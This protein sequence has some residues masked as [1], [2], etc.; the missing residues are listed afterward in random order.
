MKGKILVIEDDHDSAHILEMLFKAG[1][2][3]VMVTE[4]GEKGL[5]EANSLHPDLVVLDVMMPGLDGYDT[6]A[7]IKDQMNIPVLMLTAR[8]QPQDVVRGFSSGA[9]DYVKKPYNTNELLLR[10]KALV[11]RYHANNNI[12][13]S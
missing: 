8:T 1:G 11:N 9:D 3:S 6:C 12:K 2:Y 10:V 4:D 13:P 7:R 5:S